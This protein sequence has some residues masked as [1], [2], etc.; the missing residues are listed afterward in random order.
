MYGCSV[1]GQGRTKMLYASFQLIIGKGDKR[2]IVILYYNSF[3]ISSFGKL[4][5][6]ES[7]GAL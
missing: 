3:T 6:L 5:E 4:W 1:N 2:V 7:I